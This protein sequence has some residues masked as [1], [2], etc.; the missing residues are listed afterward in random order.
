MK[1]HQLVHTL[2]YGDA[3][4][5][6]A[7]TMRR[8]FREMGFESQI[9]VV[10]AHEKVAS[11]SRSWHLFESDRAAAPKEPFAL[12][13]HLSIASPLNDL[14]LRTSDAL[15]FVIYH[16]FTPVEWFSHCNYRVAED[17]RQAS[18]ALPAVVGAS[19]IV[20]ADSAFNADELRKLGATHAHVLPLVL[21]AEK[22]NIPSN[23]GIGAALRGHGGVNVL[24][25]G[26]VAPNK[27]LED[28]IK[29][30]YFF[31]HKIN[32]NSRLWLVGS[33]IDTEVYSFALQRLV[34]ELRLE[35]AVP[36]RELSRIASLNRFTKMRISTSA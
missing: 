23:S 33:D 21:D 22:W 12:I 8:L 24:S 9:Y 19:D 29:A 16:N 36:L 25:V 7:I 30:F 1:I 6:E 17:L 34:T 26:R 10:H 35:Q 28:V 2:S 32:Q 13:L 5:G 4:S 27:C 11:E 18:A 31:H 20:L 15:R 3:I 14:Y